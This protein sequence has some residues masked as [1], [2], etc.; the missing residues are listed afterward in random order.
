MTGRYYSTVIQRE[1]VQLYEQG[2]AP[3][4][5]RERIEGVH[6]VA[7]SVPTILRWVRAAGRQRSVG[8][9]HRARYRRRVSAREVLRLVLVEGWSLF[10][11]ARELGT[12]RD[13]VVSVLRE[14][15]VPIPGLSDGQRRRYAA[16]SAEGRRRRERDQQIAALRSQGATYRQIEA[17]S[18]VSLPTVHLVLKRAGLTGSRSRPRR[19]DCDRPS[20]AEAS[21]AQAC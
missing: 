19:V 5:V 6:G 14:A 10:A 4:E 16:S 17:A 7:P 15:E 2:M 12:A 13:G 1:A 3:R 9:A 21:G 11:V 18:G 20:H 8:E